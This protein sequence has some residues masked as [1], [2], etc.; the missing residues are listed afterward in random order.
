MNLKNLRKNE[1]LTQQ[2]MANICGVTLRSYQNYESGQREMSYASLIKIANKFNISTDY[3]LGRQFNETP[4]Q[5]NLVQIV[6]TLDD[7]LCDLAEA[8]IEGLKATQ[9]QRDR[10]RER[11]NQVNTSSQDLD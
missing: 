8:Y 4:A 5:Q 2:E 3:L 7:D 6:R 10:I 9:Q 1:H 11:V